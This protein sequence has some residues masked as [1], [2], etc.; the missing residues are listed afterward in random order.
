VTKP[1]RPTPVEIPPGFP[2]L[3]CPPGTAADAHDLQHWGGNRAST[4]LNSGGTKVRRKTT[5]ATVRC[6]C[7]ADTPIVP[8]RGQRN[9]TARCH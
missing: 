8:R 6:E 1:P 7:G 2:I 5:K 4:S 3:R 9:V